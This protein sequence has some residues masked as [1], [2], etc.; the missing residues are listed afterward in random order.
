MTSNSRKTI[1][2]YIKGLASASRYYDDIKNGEYK[3]KEANVFDNDFK[4]L[5]SGDSVR[6]V[7]F[8]AGRNKDVSLESVLLCTGTL[9]DDGEKNLAIG[10]VA[11]RR[12]IGEEDLSAE[13]I[14]LGNDIV[15]QVGFGMKGDGKKF[16][17]IV[18]NEEVL[19]RIDCLVGG[20]DSAPSFT[21]KDK[22]LF[23]RFNDRG[24]KYFY[25]HFIDDGA[26]GRFRI[27]ESN[28]ANENDRMLLEQCVEN[29]QCI[30]A[31]A[32][33]Y[34]KGEKGITGREC[35]AFIARPSL[36]QG[37]SGK[38]FISEPQGEK[39]LLV[40]R[41]SVPPFGMDGEKN[42]VFENLNNLVSFYA[43]DGKAA[44]SG[45]KG[46]DSGKFCAIIK[47]RAL[48]TAVYGLAANA[49]KAQATCEKAG[50]EEG[51]S[52]WA[53]REKWSR[54]RDYNRIIQSRAFRRMV[55][56][57]QIYGSEQ[58]VLYRT[59]MT[60]T[61]IVARI[62][63]QIAGGINEK[64][65][66]GVQIDELLT[67][68]IAL[69]HDLGHT[70]FGHQGERTLNGKLE[71][72]CGK[73]LGGGFKHNYQSVRVM[74]YLEESYPSFVGMNVS[75]KVLEGALHH[76]KTRKKIGKKGESDSGK[77]K[78]I[79]NFFELDPMYCRNSG[80]FDQV[81]H[82]PLKEPDD[83]AFVPSCTCEGEIVA[84][85]DE[86]AQ[87]SHDIDDG[88]MSGR[89]DCNQF[90]GGLGRFG[91]GAYA[92]E[93]RAVLDE[94]EDEMARG[95]IYADE[96]DVKRSVLSEKVIDLLVRDTIDNTGIGEKDR[97][98][99]GNSERGKA[100][101]NYLERVVNR[102][103]LSSQTVASFDIN[104]ESI[105]GGLYDRLLANPFLLPPETLRR[106]YVMQV[107][108]GLK[109]ALDFS[110]CDF[111]A[112]LK[113]MKRIRGMECVAVTAGDDRRMKL[114]EG[115][116]GATWDNE[117]IQDRYLLKWIYLNRVIA[118]YIGDMTDAMAKEE[119]RRI[120]Q[121]S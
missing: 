64:K 2:I 16:C 24:K 5:S 63:R 54:S 80:W 110:N 70:P 47:E 12:E 58:G 55:D 7:A 14:S 98:K 87:R 91:Y 90:V 111:D 38:L 6:I 121:Y 20:I 108:A 46:E 17:A 44:Q 61:L 82:E 117:S 84:I 62:A 120:C 85:A 19:T 1:A 10:D 73:V 106:F 79:C 109:D 56:K 67:E 100:F 30:P 71:Q 76:T 42:P 18:N 103:V 101:M 48:A 65:L 31:L 119:Y 28:W 104:A 52:L 43:E 95:R 77:T 34:T 37:D 11:V 49:G 51:E 60:H 66:S 32:F 23:I 114:V 9:R 25:E 93:M 41:D 118:D 112:R 99:I 97:P 92:E 8:M 45:E 21:L 69:A 13:S 81:L 39:P 78:L 68:T 113:E 72:H 96:L 107:A 88:I 22:V 33:M 3:L 26:D 4:E 53:E 105:V 89:I 36:V 59:R 94:V 102:Q 27:D 115:V 83:E 116:R 50:G 74:S 29:D 75:W 15:E 57:A 35:Y 86:I 40:P